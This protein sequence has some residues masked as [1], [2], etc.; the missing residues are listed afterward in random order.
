MLP[1]S[2]VPAYHW[3]D[4]S[5]RVYKHQ[6]S[7]L[8]GS[9]WVR[10]ALETG[11]VKLSGFMGEQ[12]VDRAQLLADFTSNHDVTFSI[13]YEYRST[14]ASTRTYTA[15][16][17]S[18]QAALGR[19]RLEVVAG[20]NTR[21][22]AVKIRLSDATPTDPANFAVGTGKGATWI[23]LAIE[24]SPRRGAARLPSGAR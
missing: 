1:L 3:V 17:V 13:A 10:A 19:E 11:W 4:S 6:T 7:S 21:G 2:G 18:S 23:A 14:Y 16:V 20:N 5:G 9:N 22:S 8:D 12:H 15:N 24:G